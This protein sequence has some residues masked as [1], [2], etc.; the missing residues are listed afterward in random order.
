MNVGGGEGVGAGLGARGRVSENGRTSTGARQA[1]AAFRP[2]SSASSRVAASSTQKPPMCS[3]ASIYGPSV[4]RTVPS[5]RGAATAPRRRLEP[6]DEDP[7][8]GRDHRLVER[9]DV[10]VHRLVLGGRRVVVVGMVDGDEIL[11]HGSS[12]ERCR[13]RPLACR[14]HHDEPPGRTSTGAHEKSRPLHR[15][16]PARPAA[17]PNPLPSGREPAPDRPGGGAGAPGGGTSLDYSHCVL[18]ACREDLG[19]M[20]VSPGRPATARGTAP[21]SPKA[22]PRHLRS[23]ARLGSVSGSRRCNA[24]FPYRLGPNP[25]P[26]GR[27]LCPGRA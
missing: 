9:V 17:G 12:C 13:G 18:Q 20:S 15:A 7:D 10:A 11:G 14:H 19:G 1:M 26:L 8:A 21:A 27:E 4:T 5:P 25:R 3:L 22:T 2:H 16:Q 23:P 6:A 24:R